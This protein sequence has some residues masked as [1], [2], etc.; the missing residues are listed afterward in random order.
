M[1]RHIQINTLVLLEES[2]TTTFV[3]SCQT[4]SYDTSD[5]PKL[6][7]KSDK[8]PALNLKNE[9]TDTACEWKNLANFLTQN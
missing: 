1:L 6:N 9:K 4:A 3:T 2:Y 8:S 7:K 5:V